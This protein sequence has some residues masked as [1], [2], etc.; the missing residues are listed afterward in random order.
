MTSKIGWLWPAGYKGESW[1]PVTGCSHVSPGCKLCYAEVLSLRMGW[2]KLPWSHE[3]AAHN[4]VIHED[5]LDQPARWRQPRCIFVTSMSDLFHEMIPDDFIY[6]VISEML[7]NRRHIFI[8]VTKRPERMQRIIHDDFQ[9]HD[10]MP[11]AEHI[12]W[13]VST[14]DQQRFDE[15]VPLLLETPAAVRGISYEPAIGPI[16][17]GDTVEKLNWVIYGGESGDGY[18][19]DENNWALS[20]YTACR[21]AGTPFFYKQAAS[22][23][24]GTVPPQW[25]GLQ[26]YPPLPN[27]PTGILS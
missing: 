22:R 13:L 6:K 21:N 20:A 8:N 9:Y 18:R 1:N 11:L 25:D 26:A 2:S 5:R 4:V 12:W 7:S 16:T 19:A 24:P 15:R 14:E 27:G 3:N 17:M 23:Y 10:A